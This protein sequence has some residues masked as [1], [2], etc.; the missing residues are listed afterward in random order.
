MKIT[1]VKVSIVEVES[2]TGGRPSR[3]WQNMFVQVV[4]DAGVTGSF[5]GWGDNP[6]G[7]VAG[8][9]IAGMY[10][11]MLV[12]RDPFDRE[13]IWQQM[14]GRS[15]GAVPMAAVGAVDLALWDIAGKVA[16]VPVYKLLGGYRDKIRAYASPLQQPTPQAYAEM[17]Q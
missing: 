10:R 3:I 15:I 16:G 1:D 14:V 5:F 4:T 11:P 12:D 13:S 8:D 17:C 7:R 6:S 9:A 2:P